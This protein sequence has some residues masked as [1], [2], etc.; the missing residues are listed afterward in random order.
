MN[1]EPNKKPSSESLDSRLSKFPEMYDQ[2][3]RITDQLE[4]SI[5][6]G[7]TADEAEEI[8]IQHINQIGKA[9]LADW[10]KAQQQRAI[11]E[12]KKEFPNAIK[13]V[14]KNSDG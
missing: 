3:Q 4:E 13:N 1:D 5:A 7:M 14:K 6:R 10:A 8:A 2:F 9:W 12:V 11:A